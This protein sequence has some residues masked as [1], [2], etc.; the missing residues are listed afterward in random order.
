MNK[1]SQIFKRIKQN[2]K[3]LFDSLA[4]LIK[5]CLAYIL[6]SLIKALTK[7]LNYVTDKL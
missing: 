1:F 5:S 6:T 3:D 4:Y 7:L 2:A